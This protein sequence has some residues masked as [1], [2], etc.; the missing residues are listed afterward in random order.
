MFV[1]GFGYHMVDITGIVWTEWLDRLPKID[2]RSPKW[3]V[4]L[5]QNAIEIG[6]SQKYRVNLTLYEQQKVS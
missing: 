1:A 5:S 4:K 3:P 2:N 6:L